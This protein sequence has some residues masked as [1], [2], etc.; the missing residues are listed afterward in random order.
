M[1]NSTHLIPS[2][3]VIRSGQSDP[4][5]VALKDL[6]HKRLPELKNAN[7]G[8][9]LSTS[10]LRNDI[11]RSFKPLN[12][13]VYNKQNEEIEIIDQY[14]NIITDTTTCGGKFAE[15]VRN[16]I[17]Y[18]LG[19]KPNDANSGSGGSG[20][21]PNDIGRKRSR[22]NSPADV[23]LSEES[24]GMS[25]QR[26]QQQLPI[27]WAHVV[28]GMMQQTKTE[29]QNELQQV[30][31]NFSTQVAAL[32]EK[33]RNDDSHIAAL[34]EKVRLLEG[35]K[36]ALAEV[37]ALSTRLETKMTGIETEMTGLKTQVTG[38]ENGMAGL[39]MGE[40]FDQS[41]FHNPSLME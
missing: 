38:I 17:N 37:A 3:T 1:S 4:G 24:L 16:M 15:S 18:I 31:A 5:R 26:L 29:M 34:E 20:G 23:S 32:E 2:N 41:S 35:D 10:E 40:K 11:L 14:G 21:S 7:L 12:V 28:I 25:E 30:A 22:S 6:V 27:D 19:P 36:K 8:G 9:I 39:A 13:R 33:G